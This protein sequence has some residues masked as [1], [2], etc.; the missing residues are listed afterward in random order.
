VPS[1]REGY[2]MVAREAMA[3]GRPVVATE[4][5]GLAGLGDGAVVVDRGGL[6]DAIVGLL[7][8]PERR[9]VLGAS[10]LAAA[11]AAFSTDSSARALVDVYRRTQISTPPES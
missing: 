3:H 10:A 5:G 2:G 4:V 8:D 9:A 6:R 1:R 11:K 7:A